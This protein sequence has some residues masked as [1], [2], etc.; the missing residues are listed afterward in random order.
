MGIV[1][2]GRY[3]EGYDGRERD[4][5]EYEVTDGVTP[6]CRVEVRPL[7]SGALAEWGI[8]L[9]DF[10]DL[11]LEGSYGEGERMILDGPDRCAS[12]CTTCEPDGMHVLL[13]VCDNGSDAYIH[14]TAAESVC[15]SDEPYSWDYDAAR[16]AYEALAEAVGWDLA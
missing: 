4:V 6:P 15:Q 10:T 13:T 12:V 7:L 11:F 14:G 9:P 2:I 8:A 5:V 3:V 1:E 16:L